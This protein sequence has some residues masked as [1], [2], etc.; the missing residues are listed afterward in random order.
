MHFMV[1]FLYFFIPFL[2]FYIPS[3]RRNWLCLR[4]E[5]KET[6]FAL[7]P[8]EGVCRGLF[9]CKDVYSKGPMNAK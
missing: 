5:E 2:L 9:G 4:Q 7:T 6:V 1:F 3:A 8:D